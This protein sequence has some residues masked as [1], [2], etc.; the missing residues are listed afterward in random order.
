MKDLWSQLKGGWGLLA[1]VVPRGISNSSA[2]PLPPVQGQA[3]A[4]LQSPCLQPERVLLLACTTSPGL[5]SVQTQL[6]QTALC[7]KPPLLTQEHWVLNHEYIFQKRSG[8]TCQGV[9]SRPQ[10]QPLRD[11]TLPGQP[12]KKGGKKVVL[13]FSE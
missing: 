6:E 11:A 13:R 12:E 7:A 3:V 1:E 2:E 10:W 9:C 4:P 5:C 8:F